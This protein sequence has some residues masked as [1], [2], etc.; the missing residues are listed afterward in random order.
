MIHLPGGLSLILFLT[1]SFFQNNIP[2]HDWSLF[3]H[4]Y[5]HETIRC[6]IKS[7]WHIILS[8]DRHTKP[9]HNK[10]KTQ[11]HGIH[12]NIYKI[13]NYFRIIFFRIHWTSFTR[14]TYHFSLSL[15][16]KRRNH[17]KVCYP[18]NLCIFVLVLQPYMDGSFVLWIVLC[19]C[20]KYPSLL[21]LLL[22]KKDED[23]KMVIV[24]GQDKFQMRM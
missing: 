4:T 7:I 2:L 22:L 16:Y 23:W 11:V 9:N 1:Y 10:I 5:E 3:L 19:L 17:H 13:L 12:E 8:Q 21:L 20:M 15:D 24:W 14:S 6:G 18:I